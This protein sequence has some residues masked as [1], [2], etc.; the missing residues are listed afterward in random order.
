MTS[1]T[2]NQNECR[3][4]KLPSTG[5]K[6]TWTFQWWTSD[7][8][9]IW[10]TMSSDHHYFACPSTLHYLIQMRNTLPLSSLP[11]QVILVIEQYYHLLLATFAFFLVLFK[12]YNLPYTGG[13][14]AQEGIIMLIFALSMQIRIK[15]GIGANKV[16]SLQC[17]LRVQLAWPSSFYWPCSV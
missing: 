15:Y 2:T 6:R 12:T 13:M 4:S 14:A 8:R 7:Y 3:S 16:P 1:K 5:S 17:R 9:T 11:L 10:N